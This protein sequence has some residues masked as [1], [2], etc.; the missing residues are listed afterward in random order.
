M[1]NAP[2]TDSGLRSCANM[3]KLHILR[4]NSQYIT[5]EGLQEL[6]KL[7]QLES[8]AF[9]D[10]GIQNPGI[11]SRLPR[12][13]ELDLSGSKVSDSTADSISGLVSVRSLSLQRTA[14]TDSSMHVFSSLSSLK[15]LTVGPNVTENAVRQL[16]KSLSNCHISIV[17][18]AGVVRFFL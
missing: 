9:Q 4:I 18:G 17:D 6:P 12:L 2:I 5:D 8:V 7:S 15:V 13:T 11:F 1:I 10:S 16:H 14:L 3:K